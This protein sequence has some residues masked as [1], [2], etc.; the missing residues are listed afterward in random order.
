MTS[1]AAFKKIRYL[2]FLAGIF[3]I[4]L[5][6]RRI[7]WSKFADMVSSLRFSYVALACVAWVLVLF[8]AAIRF[9]LFLYSHLDFVEIFEIFL[10]GYLYNYA[11]GV[12]GVGVA[13][14]LGMLKLK[15]VDI[16][17]SS[18]SIGSEIVC[19]ASISAAILLGGILFYGA[20]LV[21]QIRLVITLKFLILPVVAVIAVIVLMISFKKRSL[22]QSFN[23]NIVRSLLSKRIVP[24]FSI[25]ISLF[26]L[27][28]IVFFII[29]RASGINPDFLPVFFAFG[30]G[31]ACGLLSLV[32]GGLGV[33]D[34]VFG[35]ILSL[36]GISFETGVS[37]S[38][39]VRVISI[40]IVFL[41]L[42]ALQLFLFLMKRHKK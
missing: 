28:S 34:V 2:L 38:I 39:I 41:S 11:G 35:Y 25:T 42:L 36:S 20:D 12:Q 17:K 8:L 15:D 13:A 19:D 26:I 6:I 14:R 3:L 9:R 24:G 21:N 27:T 30:S 33:R 10:F 1:K 29:F 7:G 32:P 18:A 4:V 40:A 16:A 37:I 22:I 5:V 31:Y 23:E